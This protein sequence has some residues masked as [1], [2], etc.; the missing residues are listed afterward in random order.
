ML[1]LSHTQLYASS[2]VRNF[3][4]HQEGTAKEEGK[5]KYF[6][7]YISLMKQQLV[8]TH[9]YTVLQEKEIT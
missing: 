3:A 8:V 1:T 4:G 5:I 2:T 9:R 7:L 6:I